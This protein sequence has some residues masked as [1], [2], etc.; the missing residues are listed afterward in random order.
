MRATAMLDSCRFP[1]SNMH[2][3][4]KILNYIG[5]LHF[6]RYNACT[7]LLDICARHKRSHE[8]SCLI[9]YQFGTQGSKQGD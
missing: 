9:R 7:E 3:S 4:N 2:D 8:I 1:H 6:D 5:I